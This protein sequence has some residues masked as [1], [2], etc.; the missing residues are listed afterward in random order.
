M[1][2][3]PK[4]REVVKDT[5]L[6]L[7]HDAFPA[8]FLWTSYGIC[9]TLEDLWNH[10]MNKAL[11]PPG[12]LSFNIVETISYMERLLSYNQTGN[13]TVLPST[14]FKAL[15]IYSPL[16]SFGWPSFHKCGT[17]TNSDGRHN[18][19][20][21]MDKIPVHPKHQTLVLTATSPIQFHFGG[22]GGLSLAMFYSAY[23]TIKYKLYMMP[24]GRE[25]DEQQSRIRAGRLVAKMLCDDLQQSLVD[26]VDREVRREIESTPG[27][28]STILKSRRIANI[29]SLFVRSVTVM[30]KSRMVFL[31]SK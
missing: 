15:G 22:D 20:I 16:L 3:T 21:G 27:D 31:C 29:A 6:L 23:A 5:A 9:T 30:P 25:K 7:H 17:L 18:I 8:V 4:V 19:I 2:M 11:K 26:F 13:R 1:W 28:H 24:T 10:E 12:R 14:A